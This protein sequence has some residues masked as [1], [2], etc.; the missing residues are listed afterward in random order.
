M[1]AKWLV[2]LGMLVGCATGAVV[3]G[4]AQPMPG[5]PG[6]R[7]WQQFCERHKGLGAVEEINQAVAYR[8]NEGWE[9]V[10]ASVDQNWG[11][12]VCFKR[13]VL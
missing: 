4:Y 6:A 12:A 10:T 5:A 11:V 7:R 3:G 1:N 8:G 13:P 2:G 9:L